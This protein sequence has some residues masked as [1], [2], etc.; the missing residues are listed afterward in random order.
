MDERKPIKVSNGSILILGKYFEY[1]RDSIPY[2]LKN[3]YNIDQGLAQNSKSMRALQYFR[4]DNTVDIQSKYLVFWEIPV[5]LLFWG[6]KSWALCESLMRKLEVLYHSSIQRILGIII[7]EVIR[8]EITNKVICTC[9]DKTIS[10]RNRIAKRQLF[11]I[12]KIACDHDSQIPTK[13]LLHGTIIQE[14]AELFYKTVK[15]LYQKIFS[16]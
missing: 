15:K 10:I 9:I 12:G 14:D 2:N 6:Y 3:G 8:K 1:L 13:I 16:S 5:N 7:T 4:T 11:F